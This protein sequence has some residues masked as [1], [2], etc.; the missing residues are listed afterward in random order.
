MD[1]ITNIPLK[2]K[3][4]RPK[5]AALPI[6]AKVEGKAGRIKPDERAFVS[7]SALPLAARAL[8]QLFP[9]LPKNLGLSYV[10]V[11]HLSPTYR[12]MM[13]QLLGRETT[14]PVRDIEDGTKPEP[15]TVYITPPN[16]NVTLSGGCFPAWSSRPRNPC[17]NR[18]SNLFFASLAERSRRSHASASFSPAPGRMAPMAFTRSRRQA[19]LRSLRIHQ[20]PNTME[21]RNQPS[22]PA[23]STSSGARKHGVGNRPDCAEPWPHS[24]GHP[25]GRCA[26]YAQDTAGQGARQN[27]GGLFA[28]QGADAMA[29]HRATHD[30]YHEVL[31]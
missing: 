14:M 8:S 30:A 24:D 26:G 12:S 2:K 3:R 13:A 22:T 7:A 5:K 6:P 25:G 28:V 19:A 10:V 20:P 23:A 15:N 21:C 27:Q 1:T 31:N 16:R 18:P 4:S 11:Q 17:P 9:N 29:A